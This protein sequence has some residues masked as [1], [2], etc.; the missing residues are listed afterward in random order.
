MAFDPI[1][2]ATTALAGIFGW[3]GLRFFKR[4]D[5]LEKRIND[6][7]L[8]IELQGAAHDQYV[9][10]TIKDLKRTVRDLYSKAHPHALPPL[11]DD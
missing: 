1:G 11:S 2:A 8:A 9:K 4:I 6:L 10:G 7:E 3:L 5:E